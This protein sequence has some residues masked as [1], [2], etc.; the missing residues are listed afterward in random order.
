[1]ILDRFVA[2]NFASPVTFSVF[3]APPLRNHFQLYRQIPTIHSRKY[4]RWNISILENCIGSYYYFCWLTF[5][6]T[7]PVLRFVKICKFVSSVNVTS[8]FAR[9]CRNGMNLASW[10]FFREHQMKICPIFVFCFKKCTSLMTSRTL[11][12]SSSRDTDARMTLVFSVDA[13]WF[14]ISDLKLASIVGMSDTFG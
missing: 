10:I 11:L 14:S 9:Y 12:L 13:S 8:I 6:V 7:E 2:W 1:M 4:K 3:L 5:R